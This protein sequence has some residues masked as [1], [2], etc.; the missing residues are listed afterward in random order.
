MDEVSLNVEVEVNPTE[1]E[2]K[3][4]KTLENVFGSIPA[5]IKHVYSY[6]T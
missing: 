5:E 1:S 2:E 3:V 6:L 4:K